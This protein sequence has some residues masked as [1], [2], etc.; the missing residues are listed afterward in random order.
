M[1][2]RKTFRP[3]LTVSRDGLPVSGTR[4]VTID[5][6]LPLCKCLCSMRLL[7]SLVM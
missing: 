2:I 6:M 4:Y 5:F 7:E 1:K 3:S